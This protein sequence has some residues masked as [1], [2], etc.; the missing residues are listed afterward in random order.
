MLVITSPY[1]LLLQCSCKPGI[2]GLRCDICVVD[3]Y[4]FSLD[5]CVPCNCLEIG[6]AHGQCDN[7][8]QCVCKDETRITGARCDMCHENK[9]NLTAGC[10]GRLYSTIMMVQVQITPVLTYGLV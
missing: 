3:Y 5:G 8:G 6:S 4:G 9:H 1:T 7:S 2:G 10:P